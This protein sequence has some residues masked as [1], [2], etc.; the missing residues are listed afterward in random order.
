MTKRIG[1]TQGKFALVDDDDYEWLMQW[2]WHYSNTG[3]A[4]RNSPYVNGKRKTISMHREI[5]KT[6]DYMD[7]DHRDL[8]RLNNQRYNLRVC[9]RSQNCQ[10]KFR[11]SKN[12]SGYKGVVWHKKLEKWQAQIQRTKKN[13]HL[14]Y[15]DTPE[16]A[17]YAYDVAARKRFGEFARLNFPDQ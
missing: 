8:K 16:E 1:L 13:T 15:F 4:V 6:P 10:N 12:T 2:K 14:G 3:Y 17:A 5:M 11:S 9:T 7:T